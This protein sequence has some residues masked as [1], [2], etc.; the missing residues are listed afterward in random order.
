MDSMELLP[1]ISNLD[2]TLLTKFK[3]VREQRGD[4]YFPR[5]RHIN[6]KKE[7]LFTNR[8]FLEKSPYLLQHAHNP[9]N[10]HPWGKEAFETAQKENKP[11]LLSVG[12]S[13]CHWCHV[14]EEESF[15]DLEIAKFLNENYIAVKVDR[16]E[17]PDVDSI[18]MNAVQILTGRGGW[19]MTVWL[20]P[21]QQVFYGG[22]YYPPRIGVRG[23]SI[24]VLPLLKELNRVY[25]EKREDIK[26]T[27]AD[28]QNI[29]KKHFSSSVSNELVPDK[30]IFPI[31]YSQIKSRWDSVYGG[32]QGAPKF[33]S[34]FPNR[35]LLRTYLKTKNED[36]LQMVKLSLDGML[37]GGIHDQVGGGFHRY[38]TDEKWLVPHFEKMLYD[39]ALL[40]MTYLE[41]CQLLKQPDL[42]SE[43]QSS[44]DSELQHRES[45]KE[46]A[47]GIL[48]YVMRNM[49]DEDGGFYSATDADSLTVQPEGEKSSLAGKREEGFYFTWTPKEIDQAL[50]EQQAE[51]IKAYYGVTSQGN[52]EG[53]NVLYISKKLSELVKEFNLSLSQA[54][55]ILSEARQILYQT[56]EKRPLPFRDEKILSGWNGLMISAFVYGYFV[57]NEKK[58]LLQAEKSARFVLSNMYK[59]GQLYRSWKEGKVYIPAYLDDYAFFLS[60]L[61]DLFEWTGNIEWLNEAIKLDQVLEENFED[62]KR[63]G[64]FMTGRDH[65]ILPVREK[66]FYD[67]AAPSGNSVA[68]MNLLRLGELTED[69]RYKSRAEKTLKAFGK[70]LQSSPRFFSEALLAL[71]HYHSR[72]NKVVL[73]LPDDTLLESDSFFNELK[74][75]YL[76]QKVLT[77]VH[78]S[79]VEERQKL[80]KPIGGKKALNGKTTVYICE[81][82]VCRLPALDLEALRQQLKEI[83][84]VCQPPKSGQVRR[85]KQI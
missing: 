38:S 31:L 60:A 11:V 62:K 57:L 8:L 47:M 28:I 54:K 44:V 70:M 4:S 84:T 18:Y 68:V 17:R 12:Y 9:V 61:L 24:G 34:S 79:Q 5:T 66:P 10:W 76:P 78:H 7:P 58:Y 48:D 82:S 56:R 63:G 21:D 49:Q 41:A 32:V 2:T 43:K 13:T 59:K 16:E 46:T 22:A 35:I 36:I 72:V 25:E 75:W 67:G 51:L 55:K 1:G 26:Q 15:E 37:K 81:E 45:Y 30:S 14:M 74:I 27:G 50:N 29:L 40:A 53:R 3:E 65:E 23:S 64:F 19:P 6:S 77:V 39:Q 52:F 20:T 33:P 42:H 69:S 73:V 71:D 83:Q 85:I 80:L